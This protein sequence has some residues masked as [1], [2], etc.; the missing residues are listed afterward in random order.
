MRIAL[1]FILLFGI[2]TRILWVVV[3]SVLA[4]LVSLVV[5]TSISV[6]L[7]PSLKFRLNQI[8]W[9]MA[10]P[11]TSFGGWNFIL[12]LA[13]TIRTS[14]DPIILNKLGTALDVTNFSIGSMFF[15][16]IQMGSYLVRAPLQ[17][18]L[19][20]MHA[21][22]QEERLRNTYLRGGRYAL[23]VSL[24]LS[25]P[26]IVYR[27]EIITLYVGNQFITAASVMALLLAIFPVSY[28]NVMFSHIALAK[29]VVRPWAT[30]AIII[31]SSNLVLTLY[32][33]GVLRMGAV[34]SA[35]GTFIP[36][37][38][39]MPL[40]YWPMGWR[41][42]GVRPRQWFKETVAPGFLPAVF[43]GCV[44][45]GLRILVSPSSWLSLGLCALCGLVCYIGILLRF[46]LTAY[47]H[48][49]LRLLLSKLPYL[50][51]FT[52]ATA[53]KVLSD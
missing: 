17:P 6:R 53:G 12:S 52:S 18:P 2:S 31:H 48:K 35:L 33:V 10:K 15:K 43:A 28:A 36:S 11:L 24:F 5:N 19:T 29:A 50:S 40:L 20:A 7:L 26:L 39:L 51:R 45:L 1:L 21:T 30:R 32:L 41:L 46:C 42:A 13:D 16:Q 27:K 8:R 44:W 47:E 23:W 4:E 49:N 14:A 25:L 22:G 3:A 34:G 37:V 38:V 9:E